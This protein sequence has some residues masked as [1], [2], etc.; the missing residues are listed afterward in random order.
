MRYELLRL[1]TVREMASLK[2]TSEPM[3]MMDKRHAMRVVTAMAQT[4][5]E[6]RGSTRW[7]R[8]QPGRPRSRAKDHDMR[9][10]E[11]RR[12]TAEQRPRTVMIDA[13]V[14]APAVE[15]VAW[16]KISMKG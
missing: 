7:R 15:F 1:A 9:D 13:M 10:A 8:R 3:L 4:G 12:P 6:V 14:A 2:A 5:T 16:R 11:A